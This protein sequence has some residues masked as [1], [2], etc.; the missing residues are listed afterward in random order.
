ML[1]MVVER[2]KS[3]AAPE[4]Y[5]R[6]RTHGRQLPPGLEYVDSWVD[7]AYTRCFQ[8]MRTE[9]P[10]LFEKWVSAWL[11]LVDFEIIAVR[12]SSEAAQAM[13]SKL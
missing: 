6:A 1:Y 3:N 11:D 10:A 2:F 4:I 8:L 5:R 12:T 13:V 7:L 9:E